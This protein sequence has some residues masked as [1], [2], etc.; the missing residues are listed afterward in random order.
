[1]FRVWVFRVLRSQKFSRSQFCYLKY[2]TTEWT[3]LLLILRSFATLVG[4]ITV[5]VKFAS[6]PKV[7]T[8]M[9]RLT[10]SGNFLLRVLAVTGFMGFGAFTI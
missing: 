4:V 3:V 2:L 1:M 9:A 7:S 10:L 8:T 6:E 5:L